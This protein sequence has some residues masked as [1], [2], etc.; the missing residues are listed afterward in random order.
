MAIELKLLIDKGRKRVAYAESD[1]YFADTIFSFLTE[2]VGNVVRLTSKKSNLGSMDALYESVEN[3]DSL[4]FQ[5]KAVKDMLLHPRSASETRTKDLAANIDTEDPK[6]YICTWECVINGSRLISSVKNARCRCGTEMSKEIYLKKSAPS[7]ELGE[8]GVFLK[9]NMR[10]MITDDLLVQLV[11]V[12]TC[13]THLSKLGVSN[14][15]SLEAKSVK[16]GAEEAFCLL[17]Q[18]LVSNTPLTDVFLPE[19]GDSEH[20]VNVNP[21]FQDASTEIKDNSKKMRVK[22]MLSKSKNKVLFA[23]VNADFVDLLFSF[24]TFPLGSIVKLL[25]LG[26][27]IGCLDN[28]YKSVDDLS[29]EDGCMVSEES[30]TTLL[31]PKL[32]LHWQCESQI[33]PVMEEGPKGI[34]IRSFY[35]TC[36]QRNIERCCHFPFLPLS[37]SHIVNWINPKISG[38]TSECGGGFVKGPKTAFMVTDGLDVKPMSLI[39]GIPILE[40]FDVPLSDLQERDVSVGEEEEYVV[41]AIDIW[42]QALICRP[43]I[44]LFL[45]LGTC[46][47]VISFSWRLTNPVRLMNG[48]PPMFATQVLHMP[49]TFITAALSLLR[50]SLSSKTVFSDVFC[51]QKLHHS[52]IKLERNDSYYY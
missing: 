52:E 17:K 3:L 10:F 27:S 39:S 21:S 34:D 13:F 42:F 14:W 35:C 36:C 45:G 5:K 32:A 28:L 40:N 7:K 6:Y 33:L 24:L 18:S 30:S 12:T 31:Q 47:N 11:S 25:G 26:S 48:A 19:L 23:E 29:P 37:G 9:G 49:L 1:K 15:T 38:G 51:C 2:T 41:D 16:I 50:A 4:Y 20:A 46:I 22:L 44:P 8:E 43:W